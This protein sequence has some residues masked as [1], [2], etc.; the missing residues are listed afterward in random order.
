MDQTDL[1]RGDI[2]S[3]AAYEFSD[4]STMAWAQLL[5][6]VARDANTVKASETINLELYDEA[7]VWSHDG[8]S[9]HEFLEPIVLEARIP[10]LQGKRGY[11]VPAQ[12]LTHRE[13]VSAVQLIEG[14][15]KNMERF[16]K[17][18]LRSELG[19]HTIEGDWATTLAV[20]DSRIKGDVL[21]LKK[22]DVKIACRG[23]WTHGQEFGCRWHIL[24]A[25]DVP[26]LDDSAC[27]TATAPTYS[28]YNP[29]FD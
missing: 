12:D 11:L 5:A 19:K 25:N 23:V 6:S 28:G 26:V 2:W 29:Y 7:K 9:Y 10:L 8:W 17:Y 22:A 18:E 20:H 21:P 27:W 16:E 1:T 24:E 4:Q 14:T 15:V 3:E 13:L